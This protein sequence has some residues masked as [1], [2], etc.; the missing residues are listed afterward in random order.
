[1]VTFT[2]KDTKAE[3]VTYTATDTTDTNLVIT[4]TAAVT[5]TA[6]A[7]NHF[8]I[9]SI[10]SP[11]TAGTAFTI[12]T[13]TAQDVNN[14]TVVGFTST[15]TYG[16][17]AGVTG[18]SGTFTAGVLNNASATPAVAGSN[19]T[20]TVTSG[21]ATGSAAITTINPGAATKLAYTTI[22]S[23]GTAGT[24]F[25]VTVQSQDVNGNP[26]SPTSNTTITLSKATGGGTR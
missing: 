11:K 17:T 25:S 19:L 6:G 20:V 24:A 4:Q 14:N 1:M 22:P 3:A 5:F 21:S 16:G 26:A 9:S 13:I 12:S 7:L 8:A 15:V 10:S 18:T 2:V 23:T